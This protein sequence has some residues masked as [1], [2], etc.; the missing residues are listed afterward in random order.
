MY[1]AAWSAIWTVI[2]LIL[3]IVGGIVL[4]FVFLSKKNEGKFDG[5][6]KWLYDFLSFK[7]IFLEVFL[8][9]AYM[10][11]AIFITLSS[12]SLMGVNILL[13]LLVL[14]LGNIIARVIYEFALV[15]L[16][17]CRNT[18]E[19]NAKLSGKNQEDNNK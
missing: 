6:V 12:L 16:I 3:A 11:T 8:K 4:Y 18:T 5:F 7:K 10:A 19:I 13:F 14:V 9:I 17:M 2:S 1:Y 15:N